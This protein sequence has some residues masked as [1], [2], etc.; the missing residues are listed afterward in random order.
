VR[1]VLGSQALSV[2][3]SELR[4][5]ASNWRKPN[6]PKAALEPLS[7]TSG[8][9]PGQSQKA[10]PWTGYRPEA[11]AA[12]LTFRHR[13]YEQKNRRRRLEPRRRRSKRD[14]LGR[15]RLG[16]RHDSPL[17]SGV[18]DYGNCELGLIAEINRALDRW[19]LAH[20]IVPEQMNRNP[21]YEWK[22]VA[23]SPQ[24]IDRFFKRSRASKL[25]LGLEQ[26]GRF[27]I[28][29]QWV[30]LQLYVIRRSDHR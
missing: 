16:F 29:R 8:T 1:Y 6:E 3:W 9:A 22:G 4:R 30:K 27:A 15:D 10:D 12:A 2:F 28:S 17:T 25:P 18:P 20:G 7:P 14:G 26:A 21:F 23:I 13:L 24:A 5:S 19:L 11:A